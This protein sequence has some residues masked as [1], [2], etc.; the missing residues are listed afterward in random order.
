[1]GDLVDVGEQGWVRVH[2]LDEVLPRDAGANQ[3]EAMDAKF[4]LALRVND[5]A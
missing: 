5:R 1:M 2:H 3:D 4:E